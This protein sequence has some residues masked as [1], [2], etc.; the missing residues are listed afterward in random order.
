MREFIKVGLNPDEYKAL[1]TLAD[2]ELR[3]VPMQAQRIIIDALRERHMLPGPSETTARQ[4]S[5]AAR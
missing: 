4:V 5:G 3:P 1:A 2:N